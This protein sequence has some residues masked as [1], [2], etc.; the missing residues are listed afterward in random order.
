MKKTPWFPGDVKPV[1]A[2]V[3]ERQFQHGLTFPYSR[4]NGSYWCMS[5]L[6]CDDAGCQHEPS[7]SQ[8]EPWRGLAEKPARRAA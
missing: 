4:W 2:G 8:F 7:S 3:Y 5:D 1:R 6:N